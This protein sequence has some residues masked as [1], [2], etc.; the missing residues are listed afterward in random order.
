MSDYI[1]STSRLGL[2]NWREKDVQRT[3]KMCSDKRV[4][5]FF[6]NCLTL[7]ET[8]AFIN[9]MK[10]HYATYGFCYF[11]VDRLD[12]QEFIGFIGLSHQTY[13]THFSPFIDVGWRLLPE[14]WGKGYATEGA[15]ACLDFAF[16]KLSL[17]EVYSVAPEINKKSQRVMQKI[18]MQICDHFEHPKIDKN[19]PLCKCIAYKITK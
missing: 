3:Y 1:I 19:D 6:P 7:K 15:L 10:D 16:T 9:R 12:T 2:R 5:E 14:A 4:M 18:G 17:Q 11:A 8:H 13:N